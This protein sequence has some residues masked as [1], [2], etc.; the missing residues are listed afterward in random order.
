MNTVGTIWNIM[1]SI[2]NMFLNLSNPWKTGSYAKLKLWNKKKE[3][4]NIIRYG[5]SWNSSP[6]NFQINGSPKWD[7]LTYRKHCPKLHKI[8]VPLR[9]LYMFPKTSAW[10]EQ[11]NKVSYVF[12]LAPILPIILQRNHS[13]T[14]CR[15]HYPVHSSKKILL[16]NQ[17]I[18]N[19]NILPLDTTV[20]TQS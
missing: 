13:R 6:S 16:M 2:P 1:F 7:W 10:I 20:F 4:R 8:S 9:S 15:T 5:S 19:F 14:P 3:I 12:L 18:T 17:S 11:E